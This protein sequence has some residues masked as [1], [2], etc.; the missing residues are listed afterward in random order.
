M[1]N[2]AIWNLGKVVRMDRLLKILAET[3]SISPNDELTSLIEAESD[4]ELSEEML[5]FVYAAS[6]VNYERFRKFYE[7]S[8]KDK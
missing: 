4:E 6:N 3:E 1:D 8:E 5:D 7:E 2:R